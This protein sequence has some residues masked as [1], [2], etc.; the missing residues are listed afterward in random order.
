MLRDDLAVQLDLER[1]VVREVVDA[2]VVERLGLLLDA[3]RCSQLVERRHPRRDRRGER[4]A[5]ERAERDV[6]E[7]LDVARAP[8]VDEHRAEDVLERALD[9][10]RLAEMRRLAD[11]EAELELEVELLRRAELAGLALPV[12]PAD[13]GAA[14][15]DVPARPW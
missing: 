2:Q 12:R 15:D 6:L 9:R 10:H 3:G 8:V 14:D 1:D 4:L 7:R 5:E 11:H 13:L